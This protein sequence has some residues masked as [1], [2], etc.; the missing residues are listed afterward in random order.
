MLGITCWWTLSRP[1]DHFPT[2]LTTVFTGIAV[3]NGNKGHVDS[4][5]GIVLLKRSGKVKALE[6]EII[7]KRPSLFFSP[8]LV[9]LC[10]SILGNKELD[11]DVSYDIHCGIA[12]TRWATHGEPNWVNSHPQRS[13]DENGKFSVAAVFPCMLFGYAPCSLGVAGWDGL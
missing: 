10:D 6:D 11:P 8:S 2:R 7:S 1:C 3:D 13:S 4:K 9:A 12:H 5:A